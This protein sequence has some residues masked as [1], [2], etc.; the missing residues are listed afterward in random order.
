[1]LLYLFYFHPHTLS[2]YP[3]AYI[4]FNSKYCQA[5]LLVI[6]S[7]KNIISKY[8]SI[9]IK[10]ESTSLDFEEGLINFSAFCSK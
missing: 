1:M 5:Y 8:N 7:F 9:E 6:N 2:K 10:L 3:E 4:L